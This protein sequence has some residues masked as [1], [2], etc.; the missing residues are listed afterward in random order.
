MSRKATLIGAVASLASVNLDA[1]LCEGCF[2]HQLN[3][4][5]CP[6]LGKRKLRLV[7]ALF[8]G[9]TLWRGLSVET[10]TILV[11]AEALQFPT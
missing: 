5:S 7:F 3:L 2:E 4:S 11:G 1:N 6:L 9:N 8:I 10:H